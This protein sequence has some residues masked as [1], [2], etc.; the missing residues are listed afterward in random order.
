MRGLLS[1]EKSFYY[2]ENGVQFFDKYI[3]LLHDFM[4]D[5]S[6]CKPPYIQ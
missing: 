4:S 3:Q 1:F 5:V 2:C 6:F